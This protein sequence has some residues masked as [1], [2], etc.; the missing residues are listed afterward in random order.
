[1]S[2]SVEEELAKFLADVPVYRRKAF[3][4]GLSSLTQEEMNEY[5]M[6]LVENPNSGAFWREYER[7]IRQIPAKWSE[8]RQREIHDAARIKAL[9]LPANPEGRPRK[10]ALAIEAAR[11]KETGLSYAQIAVRLNQKHGKG[12]TTKE[13]IRGLLKSRRVRK[14]V[15][16]P[17]KT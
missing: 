8:Y 10:D 4:Q 7:L 5:V 15:P 17:E 16:P 14:T 9:L 3:E 13:N 11:L 6:E 12:T 2:Q 1:V